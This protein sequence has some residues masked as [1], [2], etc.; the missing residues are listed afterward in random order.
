MTPVR[1]DA[2]AGALM[3]NQGGEATIVPILQNSATVLADRPYSPSYGQQ[4][5][6][7]HSFGTGTYPYQGNPNVVTSPL[8]YDPMDQVQQRQR[9]RRHQAQSGDGEQVPEDSGRSDPQRDRRVEAA[10]TRLLGNVPDDI[11]S[12]FDL[13]MYVSKANNGPMGQRMYIF[14]RDRAGGLNPYAEWRVSTGREQVELHKGRKTYTNTP[15][16]IFKID[17]DRMY[18]MWYSR[19]YDNAPMPHTMFY[20]MT[21]NGRKTGLAIHAAAGASKIARLGRRDSGGCV[22]LSPKNARELFYK[23]KNTTAGMVPVFQTNERGSTDRWGHVVRDATGNLQLTDGY[24][25]LL[26]VENFDGSGVVGPVV[27]YTH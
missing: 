11:E 7:P 23:V 18:T 9:L 14:E 19:L 12:Y 10:Q 13:F 21:I 26:M 3:V 22:R 4:Q 1:A 24:K 5:P 15:E 2:P 20:D 8:V 16:G 27:A 17:P 6:G 25:A